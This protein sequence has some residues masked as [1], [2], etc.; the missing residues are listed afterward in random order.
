MNNTY[1]K[2]IDILIETKKKGPTPDET[3]TMHGHYEDL[4][5]Y[6]KHHH[7]E[8]NHPHTEEGVT[9]A[10]TIPHSDFMGFRERQGKTK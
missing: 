7:P 5:A 2:I 1:D 8:L 10:G 6:M 9:K 3:A 4:K